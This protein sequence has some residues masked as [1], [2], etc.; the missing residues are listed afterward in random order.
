M[1][2]PLYRRERVPVAT[3]PEAGRSSVPVWTAGENLDPTSVR[4]LREGD[5]LEDSG[6]DGRIILRWIFERLNEEHRLEQ[7]CINVGLCTSIKF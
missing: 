6:V 4:N 2:R 7:K 3:I 1:S 5:H